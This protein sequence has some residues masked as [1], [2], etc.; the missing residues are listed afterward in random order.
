MSERLLG[1]N[2]KSAH[3]PLRNVAIAQTAAPANAHVRPA[4]LDLNRNA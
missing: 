2:N 4:H 1:I 3:D